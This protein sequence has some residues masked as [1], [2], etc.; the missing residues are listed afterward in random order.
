MF[1]AT[2][3]SLRGI[4][5]LQSLSQAELAGLE[6]HCRWRRVAAGQRILDQLDDDR[7]VFFVVEGSVRA[8]LFRN[9]T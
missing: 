3:H 8:I 5:L 4:R 6:Q 2:G 1:R 9:R 7:D